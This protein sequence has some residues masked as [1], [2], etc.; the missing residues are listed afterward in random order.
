M[1]VQ[2]IKIGA[3]NPDAILFNQYTPEEKTATIDWVKYSSDG[4]GYYVRG[5]WI[6]PTMTAEYL[7]YWWPWDLSVTNGALK[8]TN[9][10]ARYWG[11]V[12]DG[13]HKN[14]T[15]GI[16]TSFPT[17]GY[18]IT[19]VSINVY[20]TTG[21]VDDTSALDL[22]EK[23]I[24]IT[25]LDGR[26]DNTTWVTNSGSECT[27]SE[28]KR[29]LT[30]TKV[31]KGHVVCH[32]TDYTT[33]NIATIRTLLTDL[34]A[35]VSGLEYWT[36]DYTA[37]DLSNVEC[38]DAYAGD[39]QIFHKDK[40]MQNC[41]VKYGYAKDGQ[42]DETKAYG[43]PYDVI[44][45]STPSA[46]TDGNVKLPMITD[47]ADYILADKYVA[48]RI[49]PKNK[50]VWDEIK[51]AY[52][53]K[54]L[55]W[56]Q[57]KWIWTESGVNGELTINISKESDGTTVQH[58]LAEFL[59]STNVTKINVVTD[60]TVIGHD[61][62]RKAKLLREISFKD[63]SGNDKGIPGDC[64]GMFENCYSL[65]SIPDT[66]L[67]WANISFTPWMFAGC[68][69]LKEIPYTKGVC[70]LRSVQQM[71]QGCS[72][73]TSVNASLDFSRV[74]PQSTSDGEY[75]NGGYLAFSN[76]KALTT[77][78]LSGLN[79]GS[80]YFDGTGTDEN[81]HGEL[82][83]LDADSVKTLFADLIDLTTHDANKCT[84][85]YMNDCRLWTYKNSDVT[86]STQTVYI[87]EYVTSL[88]DTIDE[89]SFY[90]YWKK[91]KDDQ[92]GVIPEP[93]TYDFKVRGLSVLEADELFV[94]AYDA[95]TNTWTQ[96]A[97]VTEDRTIHLVDYNVESYDGLGF[98]GYNSTSQSDRDL[99]I[100]L[101][102]A[103]DETNPYV[104]SAELHCPSEWNDKITTEMV[105]S[106]YEKGWDVYIGGTEQA[107][108]LEEETKPVE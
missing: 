42:V 106:A 29:T 3:D 18:A 45:I 9:S 92:Y 16:N 63:T 76:C 98:I 90:V 65:E 108:N 97:E 73:L 66:L 41:W 77:I 34:Y 14:L 71:F 62:F 64:S 2:N 95:T 13:T 54:S 49:D 75:S 17:N 72:S 82:P 47:L 61:L 83:S 93:L 30:I 15:S 25:F 12:Q 87:D 107:Q 38:W 48:W 50:E 104:S 20:T 53:G 24:V 36:T 105:S 8:D 67:S 51:A 55:N 44:R 79:H 35:D 94:Y 27:W 39:T 1:D 78:A 96:V 84:R 33:D 43:G 5:I 31:A 11:Y 102:N 19:G 10:G 21:N 85:A 99:V 58:D 101:Q 86:K 32:S 37:R 57:A 91:S 60:N 59:F 103:Y 68:Y 52:D 81:S 89:S 88:P 80:W 40:T 22:S 70:K 6:A 56:K 46:I 69:S 26:F 7:N 28:D 74:H 23:P 100:E 4:G